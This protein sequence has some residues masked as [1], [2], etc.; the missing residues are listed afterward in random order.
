MGPKIVGLSDD[1]LVE[2]LRRGDEEAFSL[3]YRQHQARLYRFAY[4][5]SASHSIA[6][7]T[8]QETFLTLIRQPERFDPARGSVSAFLFGIA[9]NHVLRALERDRRFEPLEVDPPSNGT[10]GKSP[11]HDLAPEGEDTSG[12]LSQ[13]ERRER[14]EGVRRAVLSLPTV[15]REVVVLCD[16]EQRSYADAAVR[17]DCPVGTVRSRLNRARGLLLAKLGT[18]HDAGDDAGD[19][20]AGDQAGRWRRLG[21]GGRI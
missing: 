7:E 3:L 12:T 17:L 2:L 13:L 9:R 16:L 21:A 20:A 8:I 6:E 4:Q 11:A 5:M 18:S 19:I 10:N 14:I 15:Y 1:A